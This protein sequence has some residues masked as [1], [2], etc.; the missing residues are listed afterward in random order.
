MQGSVSSQTCSGTGVLVVYH[1]LIQ[2]AES[3]D[4]LHQGQVRKTVKK[5][6]KVQAQAWRGD[7]LHHKVSLLQLQQLTE[8][9]SLKDRSLKFQTMLCLL[10]F[11]DGPG[12]SPER[13]EI[14]P[15]REVAVV[16]L[17]PFQVFPLRNW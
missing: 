6:E 16:L 8:T 3:P 4:S 14:I 9:L 5:V 11:Q 10:R 7:T 13:R 1:I 17:K 2:S 15:S 12:L